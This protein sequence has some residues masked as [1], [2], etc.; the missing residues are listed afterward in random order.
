VTLLQALL[1]GI[2]QGATEFFPISSSA[3]LRLF[4]RLLGIPDG[5]HLLYF[6]LLCHAGTLLALVIYLRKDIWNVLTNRRQIGL[7]TIALLPLVP[8][9]FLL[10]PVRLALS[11]P[12]YL[13]YFL[14]LTGA[15]LFAAS[16]VR[17]LATDVGSI[18]IQPPLFANEVCHRGCARPSKIEAGERSECAVRPSENIPCEGKASEEDRFGD[19]HSQPP[20]KWK[21]VLWIGMLQTMALIP[22]I[23]RSGATVAAARFCGWSW[24]EAARFSFLL[25]VPTIVGGELLETLKLVRGSSEAIGAVSALSYG[26]GFAASFGVGAIAV[27]AVFW[28]YEKGTVLPFAWY[29]VGAGL[30]ALAIFNG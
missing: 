16:R 29:C 17:V 26:A 15:L 3:H 4:K 10:K 23:S 27:R 18:A 19:G 21:N 5:E 13:G 14:I 11:D 2:V 22:G 8:G 12:S 6:D 7:F 9:Y 25:A 28:I 24:Y 20:Q 30:V 1:L